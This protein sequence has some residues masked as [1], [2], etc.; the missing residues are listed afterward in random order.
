MNKKIIGAIIALIIII[1]AGYTFF[2]APYQENILSEQY[3]ENLQN[4][5]NIEKEIV[6]TTEKFNNQNNKH[7]K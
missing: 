5:S 6:T 3:N 2:Y 7:H 4:A 1:I